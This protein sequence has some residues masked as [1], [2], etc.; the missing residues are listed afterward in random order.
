MQ[1]IW[2]VNAKAGA[3]QEATGGDS[4]ETLGLS[5]A[6]EGGRTRGVTRNADEGAVRRANEVSEQS[7]NGGR[8]ASRGGGCAW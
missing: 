6:V 3:E 7:Q 4:T 1:I 2:R 5:L 8:Q